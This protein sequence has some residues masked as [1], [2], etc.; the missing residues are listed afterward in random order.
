[1]KNLHGIYIEETGINHGNLH[2]LSLETCQ[3]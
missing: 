3:M 1:M 2:A